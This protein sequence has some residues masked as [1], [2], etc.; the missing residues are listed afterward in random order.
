LVFHTRV[1]LS[2]FILL[3]SSSLASAQAVASDG[4]SWTGAYG[5]ASLG[6]NILK[7]NSGSSCVGPTFT[8]LSGFSAPVAANVPVGRPPVI[9]VV[10]VAPVPPVFHGPTF[11]DCYGPSN[12]NERSASATADLHVGYNYQ[13]MRDR[14]VV[15]GLEAG[16]QPTH[17]EVDHRAVLGDDD[18][19]SGVAID[20][21]GTVTLRAGYAFDRFLAYGLGGL[22][23]ADMRLN[24]NVLVNDVT[25]G[26]G[27][28]IYT[29]AQ[30]PYAVRLGYVAGGGIAYAL[31]DRLSLRLEGMHY[32]FGTSS[33]SALTVPAAGELLPILPA[34]TANVH[35][36][37]TLVRAGIDYRFSNFD[38][39]SPST[40]LVEV[41][42]PTSR[43]WAVMAGL[44]YFYSSGSFR[45]KLSAPGNISQLNSALSYNA[46]TAHAAETFVRID[47]VPSGFFLKGYL[48]AGAV[49]SGHLTDEDFPPGVRPYSNT[50]SRVQDGDIAYV[51]TDVGK[52]VLKGEHYSLGGF[53]GYHH[54][55]E[56]VD[57]YGCAQTASNRSICTP[58]VSQDVKGLSEDVAWDALRVGGSAVFRYDRL[59]LGID[60]AYLPAVLLS[61]YDHHWLRPVINGQPQRGF[62]N[63]VQFE[64]DLSYDVTDAVAVGIGGR[65]WSMAANGHAQFPDVEPS[66]VHFSSERFGGFAQVS[67]KFNK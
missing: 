62:G 3:G 34:Q 53:V 36:A 54:M 11:A 2:A 29:S 66:P 7:G 55:S 28:S 39:A 44:R 8:G 20:R 58:T 12:F 19:H 63:G 52:D 64:A 1:V 22:A 37:G 49:A 27:A 38:L 26:N 6:A 57:S 24:R 14:G 17:A 48:G 40:S 45:F 25:N 10:P 5:G 21:I 51:T 67:Y 18:S 23:I 61:G 15:L 4:Y 65:Y 35:T 32:D 9:P 56:T 42:S 46:L 33:A 59:K 43:T 16:F 13:F 41:E 31:S 60:A 30:A 50:I 47:H